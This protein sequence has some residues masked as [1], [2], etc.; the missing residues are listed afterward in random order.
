MHACMCG[1]VVAVVHAC[2]CGGVQLAVVV[3]GFEPKTWTN[4]V[5]VVLGSVC[6]CLRFIMYIVFCLHVCLHIRRGH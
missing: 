5:F 2:R 4:K 6:V 1:G 3:L